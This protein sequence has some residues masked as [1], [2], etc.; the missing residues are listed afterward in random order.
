MVQLGVGKISVVINTLNEE[1]NL[2][3]AIASVKGLADEIVVVDMESE[4]KTVEVAKKLGAKVFSHKKTAR[5]RGK[6]RSRH[7]G[8]GH[9]KRCISNG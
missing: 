6:R 3:K 2:P 5:G 9:G 7:G 8:T 1:K 4:D